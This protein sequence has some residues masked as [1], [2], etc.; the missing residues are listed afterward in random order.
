MTVVEEIYWRITFIVLLALKVISMSFRDAFQNYIDHPQNHKS[1]ILYQDENALIIQDMFP[2]SLRHYLVIPRSRHHTR[3]HPLEV[4]KDHK[5]YDQM[6]DYVM[7]AKQLIVDSLLKYELIDND[8]FQVLEF[9]NR[10]IQSGVHSIPSLNNLHIHVMTTDF[11]SPRLKH[12]KHYNSFNTDFFVDFDDLQLLESDDGISD[13]GSAYDTD[14]ER[15][16]QFE[17]NPKR[18]NDLIKNTPLK[19][20][21]CNQSFGNSFKSLKTHLAEEF[22]KK[23]D[24]SK[25]CTPN[26]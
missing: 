13:Q 18:L 15:I 24:T 1:S 4:F 8:P 9:K 12:K 23:Y 7:K 16:P 17:R 26:A 5:F 25:N 11:H 6:D 14:E 19:C 22:S 21:T 3:D 10:Y 2:K 20:R